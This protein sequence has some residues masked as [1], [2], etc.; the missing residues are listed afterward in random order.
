DRLH[1]V[2]GNHDAYRGQGSYTGDEWIELPGVSVA[3]LDTVR[4]EE[5]T[6]S[7]TKD[8]LEWLDDNVGGSCRPG[9]M[10]GQHQ[11]GSSGQRH[12]E[13]FGLDPDSSDALT[14][15]VARHP[16]ILAYTAG[17]THRHRVRSMSCGVPS[18][19]V[20]CVKDFPGVWAE[21][22]VY[23]GGITQ[24]AHRIS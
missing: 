11:P 20:G 3:L 2:R 14:E 16:Q 23:E 1:V 4:S 17:H 9:I 19:E 10:M 12:N 18:I 15:V 21:Y 13:Y 22:R 5:T 7:I 6:G 8:Q 24:I